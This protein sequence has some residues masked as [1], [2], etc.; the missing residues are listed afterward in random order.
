MRTCWIVDFAVPD[1]HWVTLKEN[2]KEN[3]YQ[4]F[5]WE[6]KNYRKWKSW[7]CQF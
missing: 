1:D 5:A 2:E 6:L 3:K 4:D 7:W